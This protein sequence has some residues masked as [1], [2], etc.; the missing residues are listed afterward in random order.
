VSLIGYSLLQYPQII[1]LAL[2]SSCPFNSP[3]KWQISPI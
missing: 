1:V 3:F 2:Y